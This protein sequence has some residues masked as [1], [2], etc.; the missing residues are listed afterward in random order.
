M[1]SRSLGRTRVALGCLLA[2]LLIGQVGSA[3]QPG[4]TVRVFVTHGDGHTEFVD[5]DAKASAEDVKKALRG[6]K[7]ILVADTEAAA[8]VVVRVLHRSREQTGR[9]VAIATS[10][11]MVVAGPV[12]ERVVVASIIVGN[13]SQE[14]SGAHVRSWGAAA[15]KLVDQVEARVRENRSRIIDRR[16]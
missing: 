1:L 2:G 11:T 16:K 15:G 5:P 10:P 13:F 14:M 8:D 6:R 3:T 7:G 12:R 9:S 4:V